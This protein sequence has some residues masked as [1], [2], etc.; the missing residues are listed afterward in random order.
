MAKL[1]F[2]D[3]TKMSNRLAWFK[4]KFFYWSLAINVLLIAYIAIE[5]LNH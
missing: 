3:A 2:K 5:K 4:I 1:R